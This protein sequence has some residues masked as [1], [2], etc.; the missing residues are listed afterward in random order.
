MSAI[1]SFHCIWNPATSSCKNG[2]YLASI[3]GNSV[4]T[5]VEIIVKSYKEETETILT[6]F[7]EKSNLSNK[8]FLHFA[9]ILIILEHY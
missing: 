1:G 5:R 2:K 3:I 8:K 4:I 9:C 7:S 6:N